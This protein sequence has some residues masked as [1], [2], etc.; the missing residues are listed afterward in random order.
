MRYLIVF[1]IARGLF[2]AAAWFVKTCFQVGVMLGTGIG[3]LLTPKKKI[4]QVD[5]TKDAESVRSL[6]DE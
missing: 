1:I 3:R 2:S 4:P 5:P 6:R